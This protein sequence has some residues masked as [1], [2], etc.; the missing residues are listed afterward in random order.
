LAQGARI[1][2]ERRR[3]AVMEDEKQ[4]VRLGRSID[5][6]KNRIGF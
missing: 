6:H 5:P 1:Q 3:L 2:D 4:F